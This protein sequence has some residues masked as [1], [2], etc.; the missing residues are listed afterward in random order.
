M[1]VRQEVA[2]ISD[3]STHSSTQHVREHEEMTSCPL[4]EIRGHADTLILFL[5]SLSKCPVE[6]HYC[7]MD[8][9]A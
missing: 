7:V 3:L 9:A 5:Y 6:P 8:Q 4:R 1:R 2:R